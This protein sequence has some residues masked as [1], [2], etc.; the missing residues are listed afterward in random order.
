[1]ILLNKPYFGLLY[2]N[3]AVWKFTEDL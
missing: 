1:M 3:Q 2:A